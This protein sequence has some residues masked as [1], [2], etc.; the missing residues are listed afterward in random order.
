[1]VAGDA[2]ARGLVAGMVVALWLS[3]GVRC[4]QGADQREAPNGGGAPIHSGEDRVRALDA[5]I[6]AAVERGLRDSATL[7]G[8][9]AQFAA[10]NLIVYLARGACPGRRVLG[11]VVSVDQRGPIR[12]V[13]IHFLLLQGGEN[14]ALGQ[15]QARLV[16][17]IG[18]ELQ[19]ALEIAHDATIVDLKT[20]ERSYARRGAYESTVGFETDAAMETGERVFR[21]ITQ[22]GR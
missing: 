21:E 10:S 17:Q 5:P 8:V 22:R 15:S 20:L 7:R 13:R 9:V 12:Y 1:M 11:C 6:R 14:S 2:G 19:H 18:H 16:A 4:L 3:G